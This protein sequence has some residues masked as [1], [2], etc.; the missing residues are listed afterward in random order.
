MQSVLGPFK[1]LQRP[2]TLRVDLQG[3]LQVTQAGVRL[4]QGSQQQPGIFLSGIEGGSS[5]SQ[6]PGGQAVS[7]LEGL[8]GL[9]KKLLA[10]CGGF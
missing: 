8:L 10:S 7:Q 3:A 5:H 4:T 2:R 6:S 1:A 9:Y